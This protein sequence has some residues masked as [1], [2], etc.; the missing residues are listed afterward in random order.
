[1]IAL[2]LALALVAACATV[3][4]VVASATTSTA[5]TL[6]ALG[7]TISVRPLALFIGGALS[8]I[9]FGLGFALISRGTRRQARTHKELKQL[10]KDHAVA[11]TRTTDDSTD[12]GTDQR[13]DD[14]TTDSTRKGA[15]NDTSKSTADGTDKD[16]AGAATQVPEAPPERH[17]GAE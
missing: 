12:H 17:P 4:A 16:A 7:V 3:F 15:N 10:R 1:V 14:S 6:T 8:V 5:I 2:G 13:A 11:A 9:L